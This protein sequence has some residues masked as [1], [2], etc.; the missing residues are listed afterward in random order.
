M[1]SRV[2]SVISRVVLF[3]DR[4]GEGGNRTRNSRFL[5][6]VRYR[7]ATSPRRRSD[8][9]HGTH[10]ANP[11]APRAPPA[12]CRGD[13]SSAPPQPVKGAIRRVYQTKNPGD[14]GLRGRVFRMEFS[15][16]PGDSG[17]RACRPV[18]LP[19]HSIATKC[20]TMPRIVTTSPTRPRYERLPPSRRESCFVTSQFT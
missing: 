19:E 11:R 18:G 4:G 2:T 17:E 10:A 9:V 12:A 14:A 15:T 3:R 7:C 1:F 5:R 13:P 20:G 8:A 16:Y 6:P